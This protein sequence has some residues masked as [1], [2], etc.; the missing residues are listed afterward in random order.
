MNASIRNVGPYGLE[1]NVAGKLKAEDY[2]QFKELAEQRIHRFGQV[3][4]LVLITEFSAWT[5][6]AL[7]QNIKFDVAHYGD[8]GRLAIVGSVPLNHWMS[9]F[10][11]PF[12]SAV[13]QY[14]AMDD[15]EAAREWIRDLPLERL[16]RNV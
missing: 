1:I 8:V 14:Y 4:L 12:T 10:S 5:P 13:V 7:C 2:R 15:I 6:V 16:A 3:N 9:T 11:E